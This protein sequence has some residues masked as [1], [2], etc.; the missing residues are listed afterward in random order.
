MLTARPPAPSVPSASR[1][2]GAPPAAVAGL[3][4]PTVRVAVR[5]RRSAALLVVVFALL[6]V[7]G[8]VT[9]SAAVWAAAAAAGAAGIGYAVLV[10]RLRTMATEREMTLAFG[11][12]SA[13][14]WERLEAEL[15]AER[16]GDADGVVTEVR[17]GDGDLVRFVLAYLLGWLVTPVVA[18]ARLAGGGPAGLR[19]HPVL[20]RLAEVQQAGRAQSLRLLAAGVVATAGVSTVGGLVGAGVASASTAS[21]AAPITTSYTVQAGDTLFAIASRYGTT[22]AALAAANGIGDVNLIFAGQVLEVP[23]AAASAPA[24]VPSAGTAAASSTTSAGTYAV[25]AGDTLGAIAARF[26]TT[27]GQL[28]A[29]N[30]ISDPNFIYVDQV[31]TVGGPAPAA[32]ATSTAST[33]S[34]HSTASESDSDSSTPAASAPAAS[35]PPAVAGVSA[36]AAT[37]VKA[38]LS[39]VGVPYIWGGAS[40]QTGFDCSGLV[41]YAWA[42]AGVSLPHYTVSQYQDTTR[43]DAAQ[44]QPGDLVFYDNYSGPQPG[45]VAMYIGNGQVVAANSSGT[46]VQTQSIGYDGTVWGYGRVG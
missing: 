15:H 14:D 40:P 26:G 27:V 37:A 32:A 18:V 8:G 22:V 25:R 44:L 21:T 33:P 2:P 31:L 23:A 17:V 20:A 10:L 24:G 46:V 38:A 1:Q 41:M 11:G 6:A 29:S 45:H 42:A 12:R 30:G 5:R 3:S 13:F 9:G 4:G 43:I 36:A 34:T 19:A 16:V 39:Q 28:A 7:A 35:A